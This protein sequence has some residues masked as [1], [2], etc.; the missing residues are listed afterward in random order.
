MNKGLLAFIL[1]ALI[2]GAFFIKNPP[3]TPNFESPLPTPYLSVSTIPIFSLESIELEYSVAKSFLY[4]KSLN[5]ALSSFKRAYF[6]SKTLEEKSA[7]TYGLIFTYFLAKKWDHLQSLYT[8]GVLDQ[9][10]EKAP[11]FKDALWMFYIALKDK[12]LPFV[13]QN[14]KTC[15]A[16]D[17]A[18]AKKLSE[19]ESIST[20]SFSSSAFSPLYTTYLHTQKS[21]IKAGLFNLTLPGSGYLYLGQK[22]TALTCF[23]VLSLLL[24]ALYSC[25]MHKQK[26]AACLVFSIFEW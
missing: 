1:F 8:S 22:Q 16:Q 11:Y 13:T 3:L 21:S 2:G 18:I 10:D 19:F 20:A 14:L 9:L 23:V 7:A 26:A 24:G 5:P 15:L 12:Q 25:L 6:L 17:P 4:E